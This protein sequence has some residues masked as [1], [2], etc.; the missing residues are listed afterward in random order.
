MVYELAQQKYGIKMKELGWK[1]HLKCPKVGFN[2]F[3]GSI[4][5]Q[6]MIM[7]IVQLQVYLYIDN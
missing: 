7:I 6:S 4:Y 2:L 5:E 3:V 1:L